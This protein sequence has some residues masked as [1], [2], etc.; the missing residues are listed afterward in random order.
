ML[1]MLILLMNHRSKVNAINNFIY[2]ISLIEDK[3]SV[4]SGCFR[5]VY[6]KAI[7][8]IVNLDTLDML[9]R[10]YSNSQLIAST[11]K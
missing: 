8:L 3:L 11:P 9:R 5:V 10:D 6:R 2:R 7:I 1:I 4:D